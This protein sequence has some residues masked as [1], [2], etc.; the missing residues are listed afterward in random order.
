MEDQTERPN[1]LKKKHV[2]LGIVALIIIGFLFLPSFFSVYSSLS[3]TEKALKDSRYNLKIVKKDI[4]GGVL[5][6]QLDNGT[7]FDYKCEYR[8]FA[9]DSG[10]V[11]NCGYVFP[12]GS[13]SMGEY[14]FRKNYD[15]FYKLLNR[16]QSVLVKGNTDYIFK[17]KKQSKLKDFFAD[18]MENDDFRN[19]YIAHKNS[20]DADFDYIRIE[21][22][23]YKNE[24]ASICLFKWADYMGFEP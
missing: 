24:S 20:E 14:I 12:D 2:V 7:R 6:V 3:K 4:F 16:Y 5:T 15:F 10:F 13:R 1:F 19:A 22:V 9:L 21:G 11:P 18:L 23:E 17:V 8:P